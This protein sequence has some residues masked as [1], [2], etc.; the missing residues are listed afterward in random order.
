MTTKIFNI[1]SALT[2]RIIYKN[3]S[4]F[5]NR[6]DKSNTLSGGA[7]QP[8]FI[9]II[10]KVGCKSGSKTRFIS[11]STFS[12][13]NL[14]NSKDL[15]NYINL[16]VNNFTKHMDQYSPITPNELYLN[17]AYINKTEYKNK[18]K[19]NKNGDSLYYKF[20]IFYNIYNRT[21]VF[22]TRILKYS[23]LY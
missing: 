13:I 3:I 16:C 23:L 10:S 1:K 11:I 5:L 6:L 17:Y 2:A 8:P 12:Y 7:P 21:N 18:F 14:N 19:Y 9:K 20:T 22:L 15:Y 4:L